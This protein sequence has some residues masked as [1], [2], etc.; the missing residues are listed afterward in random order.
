MPSSSSDCEQDS[1]C[2]SLLSVY[3]GDHVKPDSSKELI[4]DGV[5]TVYTNGSR[6]LSSLARVQIYGQ[7]PKEN[8]YWTNSA[9][10]REDI[11]SLRALTIRYDSSGS[12]LTKSDFVQRDVRERIWRY[13]RHLSRDRGVDLPEVCF[14]QH[15]AYSRSG[16]AFI[17]LVFT[18]A[19]TLTAVVKSLKEILIESPDQEQQRYVYLCCSN[20]LPGEIFVVECLGLPLDRLDVKDIAK[21]LDLAVSRVGHLLGLAKVVASSWSTRVEDKYTGIV[22]AYVRLSQESLSL[23]H[24]DFI[25]RLPTRF[26][27]AGLSYTLQYAGSTLRPQNIESQDIFERGGEKVTTRPLGGSAAGP[28]KRKRSSEE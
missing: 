11:R 4:E 14:D 13:V 27:L 17:D 16:S 10:V 26:K 5:L 22:R 12:K 19:S 9:R 6:D 8:P 21:G 7:V 3:S 24:A 23:P 2:T 1:A 20:T 15:S 25:K 18:S 28:S